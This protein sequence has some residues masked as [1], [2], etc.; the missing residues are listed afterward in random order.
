[1]RESPEQLAAQVWEASRDGRLLPLEMVWQGTEEEFIAWKQSGAAAGMD[2]ILLIKERGAAYLFSE[3]HMTRSYAEA[4]AR[5]CSKD[6][7]WAIAQTVRSDSRT[8]PRPT[9]L[10]AFSEPPFLFSEESIDRAVRDISADAEYSDVRSVQSSDG[11]VFLFSSAHM[12]PAQ[13]ESLA[14]WL[15]VGHLKNP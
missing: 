12:D 6:I 9:P 1:M 5:A 10:S 4:A 2:D 8:Y 11:S 3:A 14:E 7:C 15:A 13:A